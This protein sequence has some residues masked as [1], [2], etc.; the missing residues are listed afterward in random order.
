MIIIFLGLILRIIISTLNVEFDLFYYSILDAF[1]FHEQGLDYSF[2][3]KNKDF[4]PLEYKSNLEMTYGKFLGLIYKYS[5]ESY[6]LGSY[7]TCFAWF[8]SAYFF[9]IS[10]LKIQSNLIIINISTFFYCFMFPTSIIYTSVTLREAYLLLFFNLM[11]FCVLNYGNL[12]NNLSKII[13]IIL[14]ILSIILLC[15]LHRANIVLFILFIPLGLVLLFF[16]RFKIRLVWLFI[17]CLILTLLFY[18]FGIVEKIFSAIVNYQTGHFNSTETFRAD[19]YNRSYIRGLDFNLKNLIIHIS[20]NIFNYFFQPTIFKINNF[21]DLILVFENILRISLILICLRKFNKKIPKKKI[22][23]I[24]FLL[25][26]TMEFVYSQ[27]TVNWG[28]ASR[29]HLPVMGI[30]LILSCYSSKKYKKK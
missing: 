30:L 18:R 7:L 12:K 27:A 20:Q 29:H 2:Y 11:F 19:F 5:T 10:L 3:L 26:I 22:F 9:R 4:I 24:F 6:L 17:L 23:Y 13:Y 21:Q 25:F 8:I 1:K 14:F 15:I 16:L 28:T